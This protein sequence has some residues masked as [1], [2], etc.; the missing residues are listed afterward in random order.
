M[1]DEASNLALLGGPKAI[2]QDPGDIFTWPII[3][4]EHEAACLECLRTGRMSD[5][6]ITV[7]FEQEFA[8]WHGLKY[9]LAHNTGTA[10]L[11]AAMWACGVGRG[12][13]I[14]CP[15]VTYW[16]SALPVFSL[17]GTVVFADIDPET[18]SID[19]NDLEHRI[20]E[21]TRAIVPVHYGGYPCDMDPIMALA[22]KYDLKVIE[23]VSHA[24]GGRYK[25]RLLGTIG[26]VGAMSVMSG[27]ALAIGEGGMLITNDKEIYDR[28]VAW[29]HY[30]RTGQLTDN[31]ALAPFIGLPWGGYKYRMHQ[32]SS[33]VGRVQLRQYGARMA[34]I[35]QA[36]NYFWDQLEGVPGL[37]A[38]RPLKDSGSHCGGWYYPLGHYRPEELGGLPLDRFVEVL[39]AEGWVS[40]RGLNFPLH[41]HPLFNEADI[42][43][44]GKPT[45]LVNTDRDI[46]QPEGSLPASEAVEERAL[47]VP[48]FKL[49]RPEII[50]EYALA[51][52]KVAEN[53]AA[54]L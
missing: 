8:E 9:A 31:P 29:G 36:M 2:Q 25:G 46:R 19:P 18:I 47:T 52:R 13:Q 14:I 28:A 33:A 5:W 44:D 24:H 16:A 41:L 3:T 51:F 6:D 23:D 26:H 7:Q 37:Q 32:L 35:Q 11:Q 43:H 15:S 40:G 45:R 53:A 30:E 22:E 12:D 4:G 21:H 39:A 27:K 54:L 17:G 20:T 48:W 42:Y 38:H 1:S 50:D 49:H 34:E 10:A